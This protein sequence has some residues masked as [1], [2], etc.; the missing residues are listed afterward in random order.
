MIERLVGHQ[1]RPLQVPVV[2]QP[3]QY[4]VDEGPFEGDERTFQEFNL[5]IDAVAPDVEIGDGIIAGYEPSTD[6]WFYADRDRRA[7]LIWLTVI[8]AAV[9]I[10]LGRLR[11]VAALAAM[12]MTVVVLVSFVAP[13]V[14]DG[15]D[16]LLVAVTAA[17]AIAFFSL[18][19]THGV[20]PTTTGEVENP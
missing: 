12:A 7:S 17:A 13:S 6:F 9:V 4:G 1:Y 14:L 10:A 5:E 19:L 11:G 16:P 2:A 18:Y 15:N 3:C 20:S 8:F